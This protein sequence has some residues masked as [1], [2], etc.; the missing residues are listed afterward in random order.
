MRTDLREPA[1]VGEAGAATVSRFEAAYARL[2]ADI[3]RGVYAPRQRLV[4]VDVAERLGIS[5]TTLRGVLVRLAQEGLAEV[6][7][8]RGARVR[9]F[10]L[11]EALFVLEA[12]GALEGVVAARAARG[13]TDAEIGEMNDILAQMTDAAA[14][15]DLLRYSQL[16]GRFHAALLACSRNPELTRLLESL[17]FPLIRYQFRTMLAP[18]RKRESLDEHRRILG[19]VADR[20]PLGAEHEARAHVANVRATL[21]THAVRVRF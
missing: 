14:A 18:G 2:R 3:E 21:E 9:S 10:S 1:Q 6:E 12:R 13:A 17:H 19:R 16:N 11:D 7:A 20:D 5:R 15:E 4:E 8:N